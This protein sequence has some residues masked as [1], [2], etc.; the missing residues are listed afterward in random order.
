MFTDRKVRK[1]MVATVMALALF[2]GL[3]IARG[4]LPQLQSVTAADGKLITLKGWAFQANP[5]RFRL[6]DRPFADLLSR[7]LP[8]KLSRQLVRPSMEVIVNH[9]PDSK[10][11]R[12]LG[13][14]FYSQDSSGQRE[15][16]GTRVVVRDEHGQA[17]DGVLNYLGN[18]GVFSLDAF[19]RRGK[20]LELRLMD[21]E[22]ELARFT[23]PNPAPGPHPTWRPSPLPIVAADRELEVTLEKF[24]TDAIQQ[25]TACVFRVRSQQQPT[26]EWLPI[27]VEIS[28]ATGNRWRPGIAEKPSP[29]KD[30]LQTLNLFGGL[31]AEEEAWK[32][33]VEF[34]FPTAGAEGKTSR[35][36]EFV[37]K[38]RATKRE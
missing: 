17:F 8:S 13:V 16:V 18:S 9:N 38:P 6:E 27:S 28:D 29:S 26:T 5:I 33:R 36:V 34:A 15:G 12:V 37:A 19:P 10:E 24:T 2:M 7:W 14:A 3:R 4:P 30:G 23:I 32:L 31:W 22:K 25:R 1:V 20:E 35:V 21:G 11:H